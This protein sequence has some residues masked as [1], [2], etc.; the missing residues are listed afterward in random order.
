MST[1]QTEDSGIGKIENNCEELE[2]L[3]ENGNHCDWVAEALLEV[4]DE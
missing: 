3:A 4:L 2:Y 1:I